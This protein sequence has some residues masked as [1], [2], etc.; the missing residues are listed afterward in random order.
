[1]NKIKKIYNLIKKDLRELP[2]I[3][4]IFLTQIFQMRSAPILA[5]RATKSNDNN[6]TASF[7]V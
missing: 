3:K 7:L 6:F 1:M 4:I 2:N 5:I